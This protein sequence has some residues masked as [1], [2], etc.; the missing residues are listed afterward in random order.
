MI[1][2]EICNKYDGLPYDPERLDDPGNL[3]EP[4]VLG[5]PADLP[6]GIVD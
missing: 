6:L 5:R 1:I 4:E 3:E 2:Y